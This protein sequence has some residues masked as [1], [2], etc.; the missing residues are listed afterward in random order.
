MKNLALILLISLLSQHLLLAQQNNL[1]NGEQ[2]ILFKDGVLLKA[3]VKRIGAKFI[4][5]SKDDVAFSVRKKKLRLYLPEDILGSKENVDSESI[6]VLR[7]KKWLKAQLLEVTSEAVLLISDGV[8]ISLPMSAIVKI[9]PSSPT[10]NQVEDRLLNDKEY[11]ST[12]LIS[13]KN[14]EDIKFRSNIFHSTYAAYFQVVGSDVPREIFE[15]QGMTGGGEVRHVVGYNVKR[16]FGIG[17]NFGLTHYK[18]NYSEFIPTIFDY[19]DPAACADW[20]RGLDVSTMSIGLTVRGAIGEK[21]IKPYYSFDIGFNRQF[22]P[23]SLN[24]RIAQAKLD[25]DIDRKA[26]RRPLGLQFHPAIGLQ[27]SMKSM[28]LLLDFGFRYANVNYN[29]GVRFESGDIFRIDTEQ[30]ESRSFMLRMGIM[31]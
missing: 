30:L 2:I 20:I 28:D 13:N 1:P 9:Y 4:S 11:L 22:R 29:T 7:R 14:S 16:Y 31:L 10:S 8:K 25:N 26:S 12:D 6:I 3:E 18:N 21:K 19:C 17:I 27:F 23:W 5:L 24:R 15:E